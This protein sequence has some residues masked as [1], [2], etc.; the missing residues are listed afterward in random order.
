MEK[1]E[2]GVDYTFECIGSVEVMRA[3]LEAAHRHTLLPRRPHC[4]VAGT[5]WLNLCSGRDGDCF[6]VL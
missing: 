1:T 6:L 3:A 2:W 5:V 4:P